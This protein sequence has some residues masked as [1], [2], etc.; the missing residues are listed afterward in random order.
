MKKDKNPLLS[1]DTYKPGENPYRVFIYRRH[2]TLDEKQQIQNIQYIDDQ[3]VQTKVLQF[4]YLAKDGQFKF[5]RVFLQKIANEDIY[6]QLFKELVSQFLSGNSCMIQFMGNKNSG[7]S[8]VC[9]GN[10][11]N[12]GLLLQILQEIFN[13]IEERFLENQVTIKMTAIEYNQSG[14]RDLFIVDNFQFK[15]MTQNTQN[16]LIGIPEVILENY[17]LAMKVLHIA[18]AN[19]INDQNIQSTKFIEKQKNSTLV[20]EIK[21]EISPSEDIKEQVLISKIKIVKYSQDFEYGNVFKVMSDLSIKTRKHIEVPFKQFELLD[22]FRDFLLYQQQYVFMCVHNNQDSIKFAS[23]IK[24]I[25][26]TPQN[27]SFSIYQQ[28]NTLKELMT[29]QQESLNLFYKEFSQ[30]SESKKERG[31]IIIKFI[32]QISQFYTKLMQLLDQI[33]EIK[34]KL[35]CLY[36]QII[37][38][39]CS[40]YENI[41]NTEDYK[42]FYIAKIQQYAQEQVQVVH[43]QVQPFYLDLLNDLYLKK[44][45][46]HQLKKEL[47][48][49][50]GQVNTF[51]LQQFDQQ[52]LNNTI[53]LQNKVISIFDMRT[54]YNILNQIDPKYYQI[55]DNILSIR[56]LYKDENWEVLNVPVS[57][58]PASKPKLPQFF[59][60]KV[61]IK[62]VPSR[63]RFTDVIQ[64]LFHDENTREYFSSQPIFQLTKIQETPKMRQTV[65]SD[66]FDRLKMRSTNNIRSIVLE[67][68]QQKFFETTGVGFMRRAHRTMNQ[69]AH[70]QMLPRIYDQ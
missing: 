47:I 57:N 12:P 9:L 3:T 59:Q 37:S 34:Y 4:K 14:F 28:N 6:K 33:S 44:Q 66:L 43:K 63:Q 15:P 10:M 24:Q 65:Q 35:N 68:Q 25:M 19:L 39:H 2:Q 36:S 69:R 23:T 5:D 26:N 50:Q 64:Q 56:E 21:A 42:E 62:H 7:K 30:F 22:Y 1:N 41:I 67:H 49:H 11:R 55:F 58:E 46:F 32:Y 48:R 27:I 38:Y 20:F 61:Q 52:R 53:Q 40:K 18:F 60:P 17:L 31:R 45:Q 51:N 70:S 8:T 16:Q 29:N 54:G 13:F